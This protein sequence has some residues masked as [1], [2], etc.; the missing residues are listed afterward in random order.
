MILSN[1]FS[2]AELTKIQILLRDLQYYEMKMDNFNKDCFHLS[3]VPEWVSS[4]ITL[5]GYQS[6]QCFARLNTE[7]HD[8][9]FRIHADS[10]SIDETGQRWFHPEM[11][12]VFYPFSTPGHG[13]G[14][15]RHPRWGDSCPKGLGY[16]FSHDDGRWEMYDYYEG[17]EN[18]CFVYPANKY[19]SRVPHK[20]FG[21]SKRDGRIVI[22]NFMTE[23]K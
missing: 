22:V 17:V 3:R 1:L 10:A 12:C 18:T 9:S 21:Q 20:S 8:T 13:T 15:F 2:E 4:R 19:H 23:I 7:K 14:L 11:A 6:K 5:P 16:A